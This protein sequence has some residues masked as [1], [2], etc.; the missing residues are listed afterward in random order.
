MLILQAS[1]TRTPKTSKI[2]AQLKA[3][4]MEKPQLQFEHVPTNQEQRPFK[5]LLT[6]K[7]HASVPLD[8]QPL[9]LDESSQLQ[10]AYHLSLLVAL[11]WITSRFALEC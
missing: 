3:Q 7:P 4:D 8:A 5:P 11:A 1:G 10:Y 9:A 6:A 2:A